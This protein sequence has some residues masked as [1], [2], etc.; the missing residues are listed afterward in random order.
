MC[1]EIVL[2]SCKL[3]LAIVE[4]GD[5]DLCGGVVGARL[6]QLQVRPAP[7]PVLRVVHQDVARQLKMVRN[8]FLYIK[9]F[10]LSYQSWTWVMQ[11]HSVVVI[12]ASLNQ[13]HG[14]QHYIQMT[15]GELRPE[16]L[17]SSF[18]TLDRREAHRGKRV[19]TRRTRSWRLLA[20]LEPPRFRDERLQQLVQT[21]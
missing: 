8:I 11:I 20:N 12:I 14:V 10:S 6:G 4:H 16:F 9:A 2:L 3:D 5:W 7:R 17:K 1:L 13:L 15:H 18:I 21:T 19:L